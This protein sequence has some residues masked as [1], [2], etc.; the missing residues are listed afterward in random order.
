MTDHAKDSTQSG[1][2]L[3][4]AA[5]AGIVLS[6]ETGIAAGSISLLANG[7]EIDFWAGAGKVSKSEDILEAIDKI[8][9]ENNIK[10]QSITLLAI[11]SGPGSFTGL[12]IGAA[13][14]KGLSKAVNC[15]VKAEPVLE[16]MVS[17]IIGDGVFAA[18]VPFGKKQVCWQLLKKNAKGFDSLFQNEPCIVGTNYFMANYKNIGA[19]ILILHQSLFEEITAAN[20]GN[21]PPEKKISNAGNNLAKYIGLE[22]I[23]T[24]KGNSR[25]LISLNYIKNS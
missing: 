2:E 15:V 25:R 11:S 23:K 17:K 21:P 5:G 22:A 13:L 16:A 12:R 8:L 9:S 7:R 1:L 3:E 20:M 19:D 10:I 14:A 6:I 18:A 4:R 24:E